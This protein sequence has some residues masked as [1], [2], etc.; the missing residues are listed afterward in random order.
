[1]TAYVSRPTRTQV[2]N[3][4]ILESSALDHLLPVKDLNFDDYILFDSDHKTQ[5]FFNLTR[6]KI[7]EK[8]KV[9]IWLE[10]RFNSFFENWVD[11]RAS[12]SRLKLNLIT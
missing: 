2:P 10:S 11:S 3:I 6:F 9:W 1:M 8:F 7:Q 4:S 12:D 5:L